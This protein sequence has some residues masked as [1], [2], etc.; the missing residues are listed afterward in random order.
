MADG[1]ELVNHMYITDWGTIFASVTSSRSPRGKTALVGCNHPLIPRLGQ[2]SSAAVVVNSVQV[3]GLASA[4]AHA[5][6]PRA[7]HR[8][9]PGAGRSR[10]LPLL[11][12]CAG[13]WERLP[14]AQPVIVNIDA[15]M[16]CAPCQTLD[17]PPVTRLWQAQQR[18]THPE[19]RQRIAPDKRSLLIPGVISLSSPP[20]MAESL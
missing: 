10:R 13:V 8:A 6:P 9:V 19:L 11:H 12:V 15:A 20:S 18:C 4:C 3:Y 2:W 14:A 7:G 1:R 5:V 17:L 16:P